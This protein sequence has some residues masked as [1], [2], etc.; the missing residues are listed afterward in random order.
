MRKRICP[1]RMEKI[2]YNKYQTNL[3]IVEVDRNKNIRI[4]RQLRLA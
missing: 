4:S 1:V 2:P 3:G